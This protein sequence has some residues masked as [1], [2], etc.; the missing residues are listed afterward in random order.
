MPIQIRPLTAADAQAFWDLRLRGFTES[1]GSFNTE[2][3][4]WRTHPV[5]DVE[6]MLRG[7][8]GVPGDIVLGAFND[9]LCGH[10]GLRREPRRKLAHRATLR[11]LYVASEERG[12]GVGKRLLDALLEHARSVPGLALVQLTVMSDSLDAL[13][14]YR[15]YGFERFGYMRR[16]THVD[17]RYF[18]EE[19]LMLELDR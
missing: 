9:K 16:A 12:R 5:A 13:H 8:G 7:D 2:P 4:E 17:G 1:A 14:L 18:D 15:R 3:D 6:R 19:H 11:G 10:I